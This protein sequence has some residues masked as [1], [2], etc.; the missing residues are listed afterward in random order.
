MTDS[1]QTSHLGA[2][3]QYPVAPET[4]D[5]EITVEKETEALLDE[6]TAEEPERPPEGP[7]DRYTGD[8][9]PEGY[10]S[11]IEKETGD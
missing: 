1:R 3:G 11:E 10:E 7:V 6:P 9:T 5:E 2:Q 8:P 4:E